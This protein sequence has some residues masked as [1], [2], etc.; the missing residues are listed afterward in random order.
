MKKKKIHIVLYSLIIIGICILFINFF[1]NNTYKNDIGQTLKNKIY[2]TTNLKTNYSKISLSIWEHFPYISINIDDLFLYDSIQST[3]NDTVIYSVKA[4]VN[5]NIIDLLVKKNIIQ[6]IY[7]EEGIINLNKNQHQFLNQKYKAK[8]AQKN[9]N[10]KE[11]LLVNIKFKFLDDKS[12][13]NI[14]CNINE[15]LIDIDKD[16]YDLKGKIFSK[17]VQIGKINY[18][19]EITSSLNL[20][21]KF[22]NN[23]ILIIKGSHILIE[24]VLAEISGII[25]RKRLL[26]LS[27]A[28]EEQQIKHIIRYMPK[29]FRALTKSFLAEGLMDCKGE[30]I[31]KSDDK[32]PSFTMDFKIKTGVFELKDKPIK[33]TNISTNGKIT[34]GNLK[35]FQ[36]SEIEFSNFSTNLAN[37]NIFGDFKINNLN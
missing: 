10:I 14:N 36:T 30:I 11:L 25:G 5:F 19:Q 16:I 6:Q 2:T 31:R 8:D 4:S 32:N 3:K 28:T 9:S 20:K 23:Q 27:F 21:L 22:N 35:N 29:K 1:L 26:N 7:L 24:E 17:K 15:C 34:N 12:K 18:L 13:S 33:L 37:G